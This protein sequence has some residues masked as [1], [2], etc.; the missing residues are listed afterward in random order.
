MPALYH[1]ITDYQLFEGHWERTVQIWEGGLGIWGGVIGGAIAVILVARRR[2]LVFADL[3]DSIV[4]GLAFAQAIGRWGNWFNQELFGRP[5]TLPWAVEIE[6]GAPTCGL[7]A[8]RVRSSR[9]SCTSRCGASRS[10][11]PCWQSIDDSETRARA[12]SSRSTRPGTPR[13]GS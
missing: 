1:V 9:R 3:A 5:S 11:S 6:P 2:K 8:V 13:F 12:S 7:R 10:G 4:P